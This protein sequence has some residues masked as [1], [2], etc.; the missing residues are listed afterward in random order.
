MLAIICWNILTWRFVA[1]SQLPVLNAYEGL[2]QITIARGFPDFVITLSPL[3][4][5]FGYFT[6]LDVLFSIWFFHI[7]AL[8]QAG[9]FNRVGLDL[10]SSDPW[11]SFHPAI[12]WQSFG[13]MIV[14]VGWGLWIARHHLCLLYTSDAADE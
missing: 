14:F 7:L 4:L 2:R 9:L 6:S 8:V 10:G 5:I 13:G 1:R 11:C 3:T 12:G